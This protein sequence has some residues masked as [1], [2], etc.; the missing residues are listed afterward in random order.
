MRRHNFLTVR[1]LA[2][3]VQ[4]CFLVA[5]ASACSSLEPEEPEL[6]NEG[7]ALFSDDF[8]GITDCGW[9]LYSG[10]GVSETIEN[11]VLRI[12]TS[13][14]GLIGWTLADQE[15]DDVVIRTRASQI[16]GPDDNAYGII[17]RYQ[18]PDNYY[19]FLISGDGHYAIGK[20]QS[21]RD[22][23]EYLTGEGMYTPSEAINP[24]LATND[25][26]ARCIGNQ[27]S[28]LVNGVQV[29]SVSDPTFVIG[30]IGLGASTFQPGTAVIEFDHFQ[31]INP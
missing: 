22:E 20:F 9:Q 29:D 14:P 18:S 13:Q 25:L 26:E 21:G 6:C 19:L 2:V 7:G 27:L 4:L 3:L 31:A 17:C 11:G 5:L 28:F 30:D 1:N 23:I 16:Q 24:G 10:R 12:E 8:E 15:V